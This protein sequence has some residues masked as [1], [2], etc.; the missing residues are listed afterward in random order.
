MRPFFMAL[1]LLSLV[2]V[3]QADT[4]KRIKDNGEIRI[5]QPV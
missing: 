2:G 1:L 3:A 5:G 4:L